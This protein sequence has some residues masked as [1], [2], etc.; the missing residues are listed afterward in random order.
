MDSKE[1][2][3]TPIL[4]S[5]HEIPGPGCA[6]KMEHEESIPFTTGE[7]KGLLYLM[8]LRRWPGSPEEGCY[9]TIPIS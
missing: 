7:N 6:A 8:S 3:L 1:A 9:Y 4:E 5:I 2:K